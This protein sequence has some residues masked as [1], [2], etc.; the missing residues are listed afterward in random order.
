MQQERIRN[1]RRHRQHDEIVRLIE[2]GGSNKSIGAQLGC[3]KRA[4]ARV[5]DILGHAPH[6]RATT[7]EQKVSERTWL[8]E[9]GHVG[10]TGRRGNGGVPSIRVF[11]TTLP[12]SHVVFRQQTGR[13]PVGM[14]RAECGFAHCLNPWHIS[15]EVQRREIRLVER[16][17][18]G[19]DAPWDVCPKGL[20]DWDTHGRVEPAPSLALYCRR[21]NTERARRV[22][23]AHREEIAS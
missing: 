22:R 8:T 3:D 23:Q 20:H 2:A 6:A 1:A 11:D 16:W 12:A 10:W 5:R 14:V 17:L 15:D 7:P 4:V 19:F 9:N 13:E 21:C 18:H